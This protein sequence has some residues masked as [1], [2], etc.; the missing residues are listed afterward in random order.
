MTM[1]KIL[2]TGLVSLSLLAMQ[3]EDNIPISNYKPELISRTDFEKTT[4]LS[5]ATTIVNSGK[6]YLKDNFL[7]VNEV[8][9]GFH[10]FDNTDPEKPKNILF[11]QVLGA[12]D[13]AIKNDVMF[14]NNATDLVALTINQN[15]KELTIEDR[16]TNAF[17]QKISPDGFEHNTPNDQIIINWIK[18]Q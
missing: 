8:N 9:K 14:I 1:K 7:F 10:I 16:I 18:K 6:I 5:E 15:T 12:T 3:C 11:L 4:T 2:L 13:I 17:P